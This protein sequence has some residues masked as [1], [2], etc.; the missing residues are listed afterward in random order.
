[1][2][3][4][5]KSRWDHAIKVFTQMNKYIQKRWIVLDPNSSFISE[6]LFKID[7][8]TYK[9]TQARQGI[10]FVYFDKKDLDI[11]VTDYD[12]Q[13]NLKAWGFINPLNVKRF[14]YF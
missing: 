12:K 11:S 8:Q 1:M 7:E 3:K 9:I 2:N 10:T 6:V 5:Q 4:L 13:I 14:T